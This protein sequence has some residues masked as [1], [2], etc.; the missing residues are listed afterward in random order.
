MTLE[1]VMN[2]SF[3]FGYTGNVLFD[4]RIESFGEVEDSCFLQR[5]SAPFEEHRVTHST[6]AKFRFIQW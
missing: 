5:G 2:L 3:A 1:S 6:Q 4:F